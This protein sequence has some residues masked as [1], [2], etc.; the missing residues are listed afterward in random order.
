MKRILFLLLFVCIAFS[1]E[2]EYYTTIPNAPVN[3]E[4]WLETRDS[5]LN[6]SL[7]YDIITQPRSALERLGFGGILV[8]NGIGETLVNIYAYDLACPVEAQREIRV[9][10]DNLSSS[11][12]AVKTAFTATCPKCGAVFTIADGTGAPQSGSKHYLR[13]YKV[14]GSG[15][16]YNIYN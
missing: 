4:L 8:I 10:P 11:T 6:T 5:K 14:T 2:K 16:R 3:V 12:A 15:T 9:V 7:A 1:C 13:S